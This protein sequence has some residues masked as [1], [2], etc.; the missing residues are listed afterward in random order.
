MKYKIGGCDSKRIEA[1]CNETSGN[2]EAIV[3]NCVGQEFI[4]GVKAD[5]WSEQYL[6]L[7]NSV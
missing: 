7:A 5:T 6:R 4:K 2:A 1:L 3:A